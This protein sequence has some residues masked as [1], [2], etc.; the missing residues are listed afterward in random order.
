MFRGLGLRVSSLGFRVQG[1]NRL[2][3]RVQGCC[4]GEVADYDPKRHSESSLRPAW[5]GF[6]S[7]LWFLLGFRDSAF[8]VWGFGRCGRIPSKGWRLRRV[9]GLEGCFW[10]RGG[11][12]F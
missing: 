10:G 7:V 6:G 3:L 8:G 9:Q 1:V 5:P 4:A 12:R 2:G 11:L